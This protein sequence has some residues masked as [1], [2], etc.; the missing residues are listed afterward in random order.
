VA[1]IIAKAAKSAR[2]EMALISKVEVR[3]VYCRCLGAKMLPW[4]VLS[5]VRWHWPEGVPLRT[6][7]RSAWLVRRSSAEDHRIP[8]QIRLCLT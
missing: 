3:G 4:V 5:V 2:A 6:A 7:T 8:H 1:A